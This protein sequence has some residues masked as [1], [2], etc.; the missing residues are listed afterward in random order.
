MRVGDAR[1]R[2]LAPST[3]LRRWFGHDPERS[4]EFR[5]RSLEELAAERDKLDELRRRA[6][7]GTVTLVYGARDKEHNDAVVLAELLRAEAGSR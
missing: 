3:A 5:R 7:S 6:R 2:E 1:A 4:D